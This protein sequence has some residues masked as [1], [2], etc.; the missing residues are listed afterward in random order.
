MVIEDRNNT[1]L[2]HRVFMM[3]S[4]YRHIILASALAI[5][6]VIPI[7]GVVFILLYCQVNLSSN[8]NVKKSFI[9]FIPLVLVIFTISTY[10]ATF[11]TFNDT[12][13]YIEWYTSLARESIFTLP[14]LDTELGAFILPKYVSIMTGGSSLAFLLF[15]SLTMNIAF[16]VYA[17]IF[18]PEF[19][20]LIV[21]INVMSIFSY[22]GC[23]KYIHLFL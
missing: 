4:Q 3:R 21:L 14:S 1:H 15:Q 18:I 16:T 22:F 9:N 7:L 2:L 10:I 20:P 11:K 5:W 19:Y 6:T 23:G 12:D 8:Q 17:V 13:I